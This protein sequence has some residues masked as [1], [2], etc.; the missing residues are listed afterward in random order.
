MKSTHNQTIEDTL[1]SKEKCDTPISLKLP[2]SLH[3]KIVKK[4]IE[5]NRSKSDA[6]RLA[7]EEFVN[8]NHDT[9]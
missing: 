5:I 1:Q 8:Q 9:S 7:I 3:L 2:Q 4:S 6:I